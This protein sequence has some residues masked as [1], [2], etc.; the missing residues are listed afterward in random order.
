MLMGML[1]GFG[2]SHYVLS[3]VSRSLTRP[4]RTLAALFRQFSLSRGVEFDARL[5]R[6]FKRRGSSGLHR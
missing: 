4:S 2:I 5:A 1:R 6:W 3:I